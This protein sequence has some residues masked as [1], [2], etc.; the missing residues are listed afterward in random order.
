VNELGELR[1]KIDIL[2]NQKSELSKKILENA[3]YKNTGEKMREIF[4][5]QQKEI[6]RLYAI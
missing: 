2:E 5:N 4:E 3:E 6:Q 1:E